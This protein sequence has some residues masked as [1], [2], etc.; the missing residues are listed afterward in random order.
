MTTVNSSDIKPPIKSVLK[1]GPKYVVIIDVEIVK[2]LGI[3]EDDSLFEQRIVDGGVLM[4]L[5]RKASN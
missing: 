2:R 1:I 4:K 5:V 3:S